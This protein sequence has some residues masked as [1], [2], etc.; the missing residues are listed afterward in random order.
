MPYVNALAGALFPHAT[1]DWSRGECT[2]I[3][4]NI[5]ALCRV[6]AKAMLTAGR[7]EFYAE[8]QQPRGWF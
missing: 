6:V 5:D 1:A 3:I 2:V 8:I 4:K 7:T